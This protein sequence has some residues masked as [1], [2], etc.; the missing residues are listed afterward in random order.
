MI[1]R[2]ESKKKT[3]RS[4]K[5]RVIEHPM[6]SQFPRLKSLHLTELVQKTI[7]IT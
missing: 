7:M 1:N 5:P 3:K 2:K 4:H 6:H